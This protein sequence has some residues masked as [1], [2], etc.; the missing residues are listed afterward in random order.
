MAAGARALERKLLGRIR[1]IHTAIHLWQCGILQGILE[2][3]GATILAAA[4][5]ARDDHLSQYLFEQN[6]DIA[7]GLTSSQES[8][9]ESTPFAETIKTKN[10]VFAETL[11][12]CG[13][14]ATDYDLVVAIN[15]I[16]I[17]TG[18]EFFRRL[19]RGAHGNLPMTVGNAILHDLRYLEVF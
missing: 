6:A 19:V 5:S 15:C 11:L 18:F 2:T 10:F 17:N 12:S 16:D 3:S 1:N 8:K 14:E 13:A 9:S 7:K 4:L